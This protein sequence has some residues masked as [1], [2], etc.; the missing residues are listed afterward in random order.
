MIKINL[1]GK[2][3]VKAGRTKGIRRPSSQ[4]IPLLMSISV[5]VISIGIVY[6]WEKIL[7]QQDLDLTRQ[8][9]QARKEKIRQESLLKENEI[10]EKRRK[11]LET[12]ISV[13]ESLKKNQS[14]PVQVLDV[15]SDCV[16][17]TDGLWLKD[18]VQKDNVITLN[19]MALG[20]PNVIADFITSL[21]HVGRF[22]NV[23]L[24]N[25]QEID[26]KY[27]FS[28]TFEGNLIPKAGDMT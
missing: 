17:R 23:N 14:G 5:I 24:V 13:I 21:E 7:S 25:V 10:F 19:G 18:F 1:L 8:I 2:A 27:S 16:Q 15:L 28:I 4:I 12:R 22:K 11:L 20:S 6:F 9:S 26:T 3:K